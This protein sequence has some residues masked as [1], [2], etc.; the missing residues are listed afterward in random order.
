MGTVTFG[1][2]E[3][4]VGKDFSRTVTR[5]AFQCSECKA[6]ARKEQLLR[7]KK[8]CSCHNTKGFKIVGK[9]VFSPSPFHM[10]IF[11]QDY[12]VVRLRCERQRKTLG[13]KIPPLPVGDTSDPKDWDDVRP[14][15]SE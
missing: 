15:G 2:V 12:E 4:K 11:Q 5:N 3:R 10:A 6:F 13:P 7:H 1:P 14:S 8:T 9:A